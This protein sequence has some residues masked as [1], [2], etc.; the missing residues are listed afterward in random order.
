MPPEDEVDR[1]VAAWGRERPDLDFAPLDVLSRVDRLARHLDRARRQAFDAGGME[2]WEFDVLSALRRAGDPY[3]LSPKVLLQQT[4]VTSGTMT[5]RVDRLASR[6]L[7]AR[8]TDPRDG[9]GIL[10]SLTAAG[11]QAVD[12]AIADLL[13]AE[14]DILAGVSD[15]EQDQLAGLLRR[16]ILGLGD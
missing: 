13:R 5:N 15:A 8:R 6:G 12:G 7:V 1:I 16:L 3:E 2:P 4:L 14:R 11:R 9:R 10:V